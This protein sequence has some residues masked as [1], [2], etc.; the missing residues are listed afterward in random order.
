MGTRLVVKCYSQAIPGDAI[1]RQD[2]MICRYEWGRVFDGSQ[3]RPTMATAASSCWTMG[4][5]ESQDVSVIMNKVG[6]RYTCMELEEIPSAEIFV[7][8]SGEGIGD[9]E[10]Q[11]VMYKIHDRVQEAKE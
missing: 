9:D 11:S 8:G 3:D 2:E 10:V 6:H 4:L 5:P 1:K 7:Y